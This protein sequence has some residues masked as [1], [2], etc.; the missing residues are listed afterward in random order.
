M[1]TELERIL[2]KAAS[3]EVSYADAR[4]QQYD[5]ELITVENKT[6]KSYSSRRFVGVGISV[7]EL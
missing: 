1:E 6:L 7:T 2:K 3:L 4:Y 5:Y